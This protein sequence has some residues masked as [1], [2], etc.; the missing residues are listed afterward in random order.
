MGLGDST[1]AGTPQFFSPREVPP[2]GQGNPE[3]QYSYWMMK[4]H[5]EWKVLNRGVRGQRSDQIRSR[6]DY[7]VAETKPDIMIILAGVNDLYQGA[8]LK[9]IKK[10]L[11]IMYNKAADLGIAVIACTILPYN[12]ADE[13]VRR[14][15]QEVNAWIRETAQRRGMGFCDTYAVVESPDRP[16]ELSSSYDGLHPDVAG[17]RR[18]GEALAATLEAWAKSSQAAS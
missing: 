14:G 9:D 13:N 4:K 11:E 18:I 3:S 5:P 12:G 6:F 15:M 17:Y 16:G 7:E 10:N 2:D 1:T 8:A